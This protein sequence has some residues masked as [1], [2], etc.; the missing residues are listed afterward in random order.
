MRADGAS[1][2]VDKGQTVAEYYD[3]ANPKTDAE[4]TLVVAAWR[5][6]V[7]GESSVESQSVNNELKHLGYGIGNVTRAFDVLK[8]QKP[9]LVI[10]IQKSG[11]SKQARK[12]FKVTRVGLQR[13][14]DMKNGPK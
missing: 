8:E 1:D 7:L 6:E 12:K 14:Q 2:G 10:Q 4:K 3:A 11:T 5:Q 13:V 9:A